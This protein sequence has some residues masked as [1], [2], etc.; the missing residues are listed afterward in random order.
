MLITFMLAAHEETVPIP[1]QTFR[2]KG[3]VGVGKSKS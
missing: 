1:W 3:T 2:G